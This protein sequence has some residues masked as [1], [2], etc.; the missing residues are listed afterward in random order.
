MINFA[1]SHDQAIK[2]DLHNRESNLWLEPVR[3]SIREGLHV[4]CNP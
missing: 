4:K 3:D 1:W 2:L